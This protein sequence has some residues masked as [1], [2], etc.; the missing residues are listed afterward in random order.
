MSNPQAIVELTHEVRRLAT[1][2]INEINDINRET[3]FLAL[4][5]LIEA[6]RAGN[7]GKG[8]A[9]VANQVKYVSKR[10]SE[11]TTGLN[12]ELAGSLSTLTELGDSM[13][14]RLQSH[15]GQRCAD[16]ALNMIDVVDRNLYER[17]CDVR[18][19]ATD[20]AVVECLVDQNDASADH[21]S[22]RLAVILDSYTVYRDLWVVDANGV[23]V[24]NG[25][26]D[27]YPVR[28]HNVSSAEWF[29]AALKTK[30]GADYVASDIETVAPLRGAQVATYSTAIREGGA[31]NGRVLGALVIFFDWAPQADAV[32]KGVR[33]S[34]EEWQRTRC[35]IVDSSFRVIAASDSKG[36]LA[37]RFH[38]QA[39]GKRSGYYAAPNG[40][41][42][43]FA[44]TPGYETYRG[45]GWYGVVVQRLA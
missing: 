7:A 45:L 20:S 23:V 25:R 6:A 10:I 35:M 29:R 28:G 13:I 26:H 44:V 2:K 12:K 16:L 38:L 34:D 17:S 9:V 39:N 36:I 30:S 32:V 1:G 41:V 5:A 21:A 3:T 37:E 4:N 14:E 15:D 18:W 40:T 27:V 22:S 31:V 19:W 24:A 11:I 8:F 42:V 43:S 33:L